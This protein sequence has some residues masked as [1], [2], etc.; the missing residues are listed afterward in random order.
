MKPKIYTP[1]EHRIDGDRVDEDALTILRR[2]REAGHEAYLVGGGVRDL[3]L[4]KEPKDFDISTSARP[5]QIKRLF[6][7]NC[8][9]IGRRF[10]L[11]HIRFG[12]KIFEVSTFRAGDP[13][14]SKLITRDN[15]WGSEEEDVLRRDFTIN[16]LFYD[17]KDQTV[18]DYVGGCED[19]H[20]RLLRCIGEP[21]RRFKQDPVR[22]LRLIKFMAR[23]GFEVHEDTLHALRVCREEIIKSAPAR[24][25]EEIF[26]MLESGSAEAF[27]R[28]MTE[29]GL[30]APLIPGLDSFLRGPHA[31]DI[32]V[33]LRVLDQRVRMQ[34][35]KTPDRAI[36]AALLLYPI[37][38][39]EL[40]TQYLDH[41][42]TPTMEQGLDLV[43]NVIDAVYIA[44]FTHFPQRLQQGAHYILTMQRKLTP[45]RESRRNPAR[46]ANHRE[47]ALALDFLQLRSLVNPELEETYREWKE[48]APAP[49]QMTKPRQ[50]HRHR[51]PRARK[52]S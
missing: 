37:V 41:G 48:L 3:I 31:E 45:L 11:A 50:R 23:F 16:G 40:A 44:A 42:E 33:Y 20:V 2:L 7:K 15:K 4:G 30:L 36:L 27:F 22:M 17:S 35:G 52:E 47:F 46:I 29:H 18:I 38:Q 1:T 24:V 51:K 21:V 12:R 28:L 26:R 9:L 14:T 10:R 32:Y 34:H 6:Y 43:N 8:L 19:I 25:M 5:E 13:D 39:R 49:E